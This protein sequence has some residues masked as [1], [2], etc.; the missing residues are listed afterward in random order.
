MRAGARL[1]PTRRAKSY[2]WRPDADLTGIA[3]G[4]MLNLGLWPSGEFV[5]ACSDVL[6]EDPEFAA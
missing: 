4:Y 1:T 5:D 6:S 3:R 2:S